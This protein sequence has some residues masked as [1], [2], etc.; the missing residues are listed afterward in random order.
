MSWVNALA[1]ARSN[2]ASGIAASLLP[3]AHTA[4]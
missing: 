3:T 4:R 1:F 2:S